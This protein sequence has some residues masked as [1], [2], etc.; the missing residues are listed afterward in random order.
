MTILSG[1]HIHPHP[2]P[3]AR[4]I[5]HA[6]REL[7]AVV[8]V[9]DVIAVD[10]LFERFVVAHVAALNIIRTLFSVVAVRRSSACGGIVPN[11]R[12]DD[13]SGYRCSPLPITATDLIA[14]RSSDD[15]SQDHWPGR[16]IM[17]ATRAILGDFVA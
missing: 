16:A 4:I 12:T 3:I 11:R 2:D 15:P 7:A 1:M 13:R 14:H 6:C 17:A 8:D 10:T 5:R 9:S